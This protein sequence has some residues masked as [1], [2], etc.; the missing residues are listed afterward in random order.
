MSLLKQ[1]HGMLCG[2]Q[3]AG[4][5]HCDELRTGNMT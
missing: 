4:Q 3:L 1:V 5:S 2:P